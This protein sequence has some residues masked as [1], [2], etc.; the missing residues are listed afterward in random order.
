[1]LCNHVADI[2]CPAFANSEIKAEV[3][4]I[5]QEQTFSNV[6]EN[7]KLRSAGAVYRAPTR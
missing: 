2:S 4:V 5:L 1:M 7:E 6:L 3:D